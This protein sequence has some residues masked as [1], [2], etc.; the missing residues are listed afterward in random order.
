[1][2]KS[3]LKP[4][5]NDSKKG[6]KG[7]WETFMPFFKALRNGAKKIRSYPS[8]F[9]NTF[10]ELDNYCMT[11]TAMLNFKETCRSDF[12]KNLLHT[13]KHRNMVILIQI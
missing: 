9:R 13:R 2:S 7:L 11:P 6:F 1:M 10:R 3:F 4:L 5:P 8:S 12:Q